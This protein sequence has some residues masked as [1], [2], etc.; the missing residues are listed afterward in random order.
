MRLT[1]D[2]HTT[3]TH[4]LNERAGKK[5]ERRKGGS[6][7][8]TERLALDPEPSNCRVFFQ[9]KQAF[10]QNVLVIDLPF[11]RALSFILCLVLWG[12]GSE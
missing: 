4:T 5:R 8:K 12:R 9:V 1:S 6:K 3:H 7:R 10:A 11:G 2:L